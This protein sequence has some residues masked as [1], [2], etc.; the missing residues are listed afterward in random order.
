MNIRV[1]GNS[2]IKNQLHTHVREKV[3]QLK[4]FFERIKAI[5]VFLNED[6]DKV[7]EI[8]L[9]VMRRVLYTSEHAGA[10]ENALANAADKMRQ[11]LLLYKKEIAI[12]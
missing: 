4:T 6:E 7:V 12:Y 5:E 10:F 8:K 3:E 9:Y 2:P 11:Q 1:Y